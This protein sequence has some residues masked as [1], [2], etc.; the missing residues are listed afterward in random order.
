MIDLLYDSSRNTIGESDLTSAM[1]LMQAIISVFADD[2]D[3]I[4]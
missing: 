3:K 1:G 4:R 2:G